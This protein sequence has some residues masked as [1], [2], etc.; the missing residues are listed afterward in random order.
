MVAKSEDDLE[1]SAVSAVSLEEAAS[2]VCRLTGKKR[3][4]MQRSE[5]RRAFVFREQ[6][7]TRVG[8]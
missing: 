6:L 8:S 4:R 2:H 3:G 1:L 5:P 7:P